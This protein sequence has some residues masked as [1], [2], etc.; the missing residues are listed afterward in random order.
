MIEVCEVTARTDL[1]IAFSIREEVF[2]I[3]QGVSRED[4]F[5]EYDD[6][7]HHFLAYFNQTPC[8]TARWRKTDK[9]VK[10]E[11]FCVL[12]NFRGKGLGSSLVEK[13]LE[14][15]QSKEG[16][17]YL[18][19]HA[20]TDVIGLYE[21]HGFKTVGEIFYECEIAHKVMVKNN[22]SIFVSPRD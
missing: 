5:D 4:E 18:Y 16:P 21:K 3:E 15:V 22:R 10:L 20:Q 9:G 6:Y 19:L 14:S 2:T 13:A 8:G 11:R 7:S 17:V 12:K 1:D